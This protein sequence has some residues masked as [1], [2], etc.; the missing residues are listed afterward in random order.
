MSF[1]LKSNV[2]QINAELKQRAKA[3]V[4][5]TAFQ[6]EQNAKLSMAEPKSGRTYGSHQASAPGEAPAIDLGALVNSIH[7]EQT[8]E[9]SAIVGTNMEHGL[10]TEFGT[11]RMAPRPW[12]GPA[13]E[14]V[15]EKFQAGLRGL[16][17]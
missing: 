1:T 15:R 6:I 13:F 7:V 16:L 10:H 5:R 17:K 12:L 9:M 11:A 3:L 4:M 14:S 2:S 8:G